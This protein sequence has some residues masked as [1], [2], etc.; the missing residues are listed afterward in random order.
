M[1]RK[2]GIFQLNVRKRDTVQL[3]VMNDEELKDC[4]V[5][6]IAEPYARKK[7]GM[8]VTAPI[9]HS[10]WSRIL[11]TQTNEAGWPVRSMLWI[12]KDID[13]EQVPIPSSD[14]TAA[15]L[16]LPDRDVLVMSVT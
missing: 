2:L 8:I 5:L 1:H 7:D 13:S 11:P 10:S 3:S 14:L 12:R 16:H 9:G 6:A 4:A 15:V